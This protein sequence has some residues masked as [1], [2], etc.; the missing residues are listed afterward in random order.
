MYTDL[1]QKLVNKE[2]KLSASKWLL[3]APAVSIS[4]KFDVS[5]LEGL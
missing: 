3:K 4:P 5:I 1:Y 2:E